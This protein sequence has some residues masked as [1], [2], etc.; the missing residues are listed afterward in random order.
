MTTLQLKL[1]RNPWAT[2]FFTCEVWTKSGL[3]SFYVLFYIHLK[4]RRVIIGGVSENPDGKWVT[5]VTR[6]ITE[7]DQPMANARYLIISFVIPSI[8]RNSATYSV[9]H[10]NYL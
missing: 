2:D 6:G 7:F 10:N 4:T 3:T 9:A 1:K 8:A 5:Q